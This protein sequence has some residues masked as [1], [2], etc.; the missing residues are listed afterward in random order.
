M[1]HTC[2]DDIW[3]RI[4]V[5]LIYICDI[6]MYVL[7]HMGNIYMYVDAYLNVFQIF[8]GLISYRMGHLI[9]FLWYPAWFDGFQGNIILHTI[10]SYAII[11]NTQ[12]GNMP[13]CLTVLLV[14]DRFLSADVIMLTYDPAATEHIHIMTHSVIVLWTQGIFIVCIALTMRPYHGNQMTE[15]THVGRKWPLKTSGLVWVRALRSRGGL[16]VLLWTTFGWR[17]SG[18]LSFLCKYLCLWA[19][20]ANFWITNAEVA[21]TTKTFKDSTTIT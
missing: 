5:T 17:N 9:Q 3:W 13:Y 20:H 14:Y 6:S 18:M 19:E 16:F 4:P 10:I 8:H 21:L 1:I 7:T 11:H 2:G 15:S 12:T